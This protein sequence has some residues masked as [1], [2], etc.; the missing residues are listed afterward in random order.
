MLLRIT[1]W[2]FYV[3]LIVTPFL[4]SSATSE[5]FEFNKMMFIYFMSTLVFTMWLAY[6]I[7]I[8]KITLTLYII[9]Y[10]FIGFFLTQ[11][12]ST[13]FSIDQHTSLYGYYGRFNGG[14]LSIGAF[15]S[16]FFVL[17]QIGTYEYAK[18][19]ILVSITASVFVVLWGLPGWFGFDLSCLVFTGDLNTSCWSNQFQPEVRMFSTLGQPN[20]L[21]AY[22]AFHLLASLAFFVLPSQENGKEYVWYFKKIA[23]SLAIILLF[24]G[25]LFTR[26]RSAMLAIS[27]AIPLFVAGYFFFV[28]RPNKKLMQAGS[29]FGIVLALIFIATGTGAR[30]VDQFSTIPGLLE[31]AIE[32]VTTETIISSS[33]EPNTEPGNE[34][35]SS[36]S[37]NT[38]T[39]SFEIRLI[40]WQ[41]AWELA[42]QY[43]LLGTGVETF[44][45]AYFLTRPDAHN[46]TS[47]WDF[48]YNKAHNEYLNYFATSGFLG[49]FAYLAIIIAVI[50]LARRLLWSSHVSAEKKIITLSVTTGYITILITNFFGFSTS[51]TQ[52]L[53]Y[54]SPAL[55]IALGSHEIQWIAKKYDI[56]LPFIWLRY[57]LY[58]LVGYVFAFHVMSLS[59]YYQADMHY[60]EA[61]LYARSQ[62]YRRAFEQYTDALDLKYEH[63]YE[64]ELSST[65]SRLAVIVSNEE[66][67]E[68]IRQIIDQS[69]QYNLS[70]LN[71]SPYN[72]LYWK[73]RAQNHYHYY[74]A[75]LDPAYLEAANKALDDA[76]SI[77]ENDPKLY[78]LSSLFYSIRY[79][80]AIAQN[81][82]EKAEEYKRLS[83]EDIQIA[84]DFR[85]TYVEAQQLKERLNEKFD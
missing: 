39:D 55:L 71:Q 27:I 76:K 45:Y 36:S 9:F 26:S 56:R 34:H 50:V 2:L 10:I 73:T 49:G 51:T 21:G 68:T 32:S 7:T 1:R 58:V 53:F 30:V 74:Q 17:S 15:I 64:N 48:I 22:V 72:Q 81:E 78:Y 70:A 66:N 62:L 4:M 60:A 52:I 43:P 44:A 47:E 8:G 41:G 33:D 29:T 31:Q 77:A 25:I 69:G 67:Q 82:N 11:L 23:I 40:V 24:A 28:G 35:S 5:L 13:L 19:L 14:L 63:V 46:A 12:V 59:T 16:L 18:R 75:T 85:P 20:W 65:L 84:L 6:Q 79:D 83:L 37:P 3:L 38:I 42:T 54:L 61:E 57:I 80:E